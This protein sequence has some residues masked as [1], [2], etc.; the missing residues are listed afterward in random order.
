MEEE[1]LQP[2]ITQRGSAATE[3]N[4]PNDAKNAKGS[5]TEVRSPAFCWRYLAFLADHFF[6]PLGA[7]K[8]WRKK[9]SPITDYPQI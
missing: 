7:S 6:W 3:E 8:W 1:K 4:P 5:E 2:R 9:S